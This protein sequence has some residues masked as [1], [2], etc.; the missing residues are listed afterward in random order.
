MSLAVRVAHLSKCFRINAD[1]PAGYNTLREALAEMISAPLRHFRNGAALGRTAEF[2][3]LRDLS[4]DVAAGEVLGIVGR[5][6][7]VKSILLKIIGRI[8]TPTSGRV[9]LFGRVASLLE[10]GTG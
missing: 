8:T 4:F 6:G 10:A 9:E 2:W 5:N 1:R 3:A 7:A